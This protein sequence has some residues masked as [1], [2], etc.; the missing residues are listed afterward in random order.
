MGTVLAV[1]FITIAIAIVSVFWAHCACVLSVRDRR[2]RDYT[3]NVAEANGL[4]FL[5]ARSL[6]EEGAPDSAVLEGVYRS[7]DRDYRLL[8]YLLHHVPVP[9]A[10]V[11]AVHE[12]L[13]RMNYRTL[14]VW[15]ML[16]GRLSR[17]LG[18]RALLDM[19]SIVGQLAN[20]MGERSALTAK[21]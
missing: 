2:Y 4:T 18:R 11:P 8:T 1:V 17:S 19:S 14:A 16:T 12:W 20:V 9:D 5:D 10:G 13:L 7:L 3:R 21:A 6:L 15:F